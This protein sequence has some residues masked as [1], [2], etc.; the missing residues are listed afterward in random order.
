M[1]GSICLWCDAAIYLFLTWFIILSFIHSKNVRNVAD[2]KTWSDVKIEQTDKDKEYSTWT[3]TDEMSNTNLL[4]NEDKVY[5]FH[6]WDLPC[7]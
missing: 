6:M 4:K 3:N 7:Y 2:T 5:L 1:I